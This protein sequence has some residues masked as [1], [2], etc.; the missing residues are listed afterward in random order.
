MVNILSEMISYV[1]NRKDRPER[2]DAVSAEFQ[3]VGLK[4]TRFDAVITTPGWCGCRDSHIQAMRLGMETGDGCFGVFEDDVK[5][6]TDPREFLV[7]AIWQLPTGW[8]ALFLGASPQEPFQRVSRSLFRMGKAFCTHAII[9]NTRP[10]GAVDY[11]LE[12]EG[13]IKKIDQYFSEQIYPNFRCY[14]AS[15]LVATQIQYQSDTCGRSDVTTIVTNFL[16]YCI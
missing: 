16:K 8:D 6:L 1:I 11:I 12:H 5:F 2:W 7:E 15:P 3:R 4:P 10:G 9:W 14:L 13:E